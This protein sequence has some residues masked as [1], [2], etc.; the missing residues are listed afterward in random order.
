MARTIAEIYDALNASKAS[1]SELNDFVVS[2]SVPG[3]TQDNS[4]DLAIDVTSA[5]K[6][7]VWRLWLWIFAVGSWMVEVLFDRHSADVTAVL[8][9]KR[10]H[11]LRWY[12]EESKKYQYGYPVSW[13]DNMYQY[14][15][16]DADAQ[17]VKYAAASEKN[18]TVVLKVAKNSG[19]V[20][21]PL[22]TLEKSTFTEF[23]SKWKDAGVKLEIV[24]QPAD[25][26]KIYITI[27]RDRLVLD[28]NN[29]LLRDNSINP[30]TLAI[31]A[32]GNSLEFDGVLRLSKLV[33]S[34]QAAEGVVDVQ[35]T[36]AWH[37]PAGGSYS[38]V[39]MSVESIAGYFELSYTDSLFT[40]QD[41]VEVS[42][43]D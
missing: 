13:I 42:I 40:Y 11:T 27:V 34:I 39:N 41:N 28:G 33:D 37:K 18:G 9:S 26:L 6:V 31:D 1:F 30:I 16:S 14:A 17:I 23:W 35:L 20:K 22:T 24:S 32:F 19:G 29:N 8:D 4:A 2:T 3:S 25:Q 10:I 21:A 43:F 15:T 5:S 38:V 36:Q 12:A 7:A